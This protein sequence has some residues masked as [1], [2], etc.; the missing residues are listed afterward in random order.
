MSNL[1]IINH[2]E[3]SLTLLI[4]TYFVH[5][6]Y[7]LSRLYKMCFRLLILLTCLSSPLCAFCRVNKTENLVNS[8]EWEYITID[9]N[10]L[11]DENMKSTCK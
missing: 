4:L 1:K 5:H 2:I 7:H 10:H 3:V 8:R 9:R 11:S 6:L